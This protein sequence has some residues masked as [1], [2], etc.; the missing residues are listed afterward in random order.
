MKRPVHYSELKTA[1]NKKQ[2]QTLAERQIH[3][4]IGMIKMITTLQSDLIKTKESMLPICDKP[5]QKNKKKV[6]EVR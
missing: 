3:I 6:Q 4:S 1:L 2:K 5:Y